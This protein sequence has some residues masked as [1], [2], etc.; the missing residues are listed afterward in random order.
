EE[1]VLVPSPRE[2]KTYDLKPAMAAPE[3][4]ARLVRAVDSKK[5]DF[6]LVN[7]ANPDMVG[8]SGVLDAAVKAVR[9]VD[10]C[11][12]RLATACARANYALAITADHGNCELMRD[13]VTGQPHTA[14]TTN[15]PTS[16]ERGRAR[17]PSATSL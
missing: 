4:T 16:A 14:H 7:Y 9:V 6:L 5:Y 11:L 17:A 15:A 8:H 13:P 10:D 1:R 2:V 3:V 12:G